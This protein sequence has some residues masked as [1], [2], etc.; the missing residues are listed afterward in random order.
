MNIVQNKINQHIYIYK[1]NYPKE[2]MIQIRKFNQYN[3]KQNTHK[4]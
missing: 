4:F 3:H 1:P 2:K